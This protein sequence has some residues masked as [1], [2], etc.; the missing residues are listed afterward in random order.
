MSNKIDDIKIGNKYGYWTV[1]GQEDG[2]PEH[3]YKA[4]CRCVCGTVRWI[5]RS[6]LRRGKA[7]SCGCKNHPLVDYGIHPGDKVGYWTILE[8]HPEYFLCRCICGTERKVATASLLKGVSLSCGCQRVRG[9]EDE[10]KAAMQKGSDIRDKLSESKLAPKYA[11][12]GRQ[13]NRNSTTGATGVAKTRIGN[14]RAYITVNRK[15]IHLGVFDDIEDAIAA[16]KEAEQRY[17]ADRQE[18]AD[19][20]KA[21][22]RTTK[23]DTKE[24]RH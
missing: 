21:S 19:K 1:I 3:R 13:Q 17:F 14:Y 24:P 6:R 16:R 12:F 8:Q 18:E 9:R 20:I 22:F 15:Q 11:G 2:L 10:V 4:L 23:P 7:K 5:S